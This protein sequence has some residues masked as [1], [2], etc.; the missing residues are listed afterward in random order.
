[1]YGM[2]KFDT[3]EGLNADIARLVVDIRTNLCPDKN[4][5]LRYSLESI[6]LVCLGCPVFNSNDARTKIL[7][8][9]WFNQD[10]K[11]TEKEL[12]A[13]QFKYF[14]LVRSYRELRKEKQ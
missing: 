10:V 1:M 8:V 9:L 13:L 12:F 7:R 4:K 6:A 5:C 3:S 14:G 11:L 2:D